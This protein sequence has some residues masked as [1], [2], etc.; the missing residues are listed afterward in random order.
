MRYASRADGNQGSIVNGLRA[1]GASVEHLTRMGEGWPDLL[2]GWK[3]KNFLLEIKNPDSR[4]D[5]AKSGRSG[6]TARRQREW[7]ENWRGQVEVIR[8]LP[9]A[10]LAI[11]AVEAE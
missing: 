5:G 11:G 3:G 6:E 9:Q 2:V 4:H 7:Y 10:L 1:A 8:S